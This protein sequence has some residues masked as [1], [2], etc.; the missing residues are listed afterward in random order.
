M[1][2]TIKQ[3][4]SFTPSTFIV[5][6]NLVCT[7]DTYLFTGLVAEAGELAGNYA[8]YCR[9]DFNSE[10][11]IFRTKKELG[12][13]LYFC[14]QL[15]NQIGLDIEDVLEANRDKLQDRLNKGTIKGDGEGDRLK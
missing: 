14:F 10:E 5:P 4:Q 13:V 8:K 6:E 1:S 12:D 7:Q 3:Y 2:I 15:A 9:G 11:L